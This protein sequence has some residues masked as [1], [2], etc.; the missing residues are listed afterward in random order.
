MGEAQKE[1]VG[2][3]WLMLWVIALLVLS[4]DFWFALRIGKHFEHFSLPLTVLMPYAA[5]AAA[6]ALGRRVLI[7]LII[8]F[9]LALISF[10]P[11]AEFPDSWPLRFIDT[12]FGDKFTAYV[13]S[14]AAVAVALAAAPRLH[15]TGFIAAVTACFAISAIW[16]AQFIQVPV[17][18]DEGIGAG[19][20]VTFAALPVAVSF[21]IAASRLLPLKGL[22]LFLSILLIGSLIAFDG[23][24]LRS[25]VAVFNFLGWPSYLNWDTS[26]YYAIAFL[27]IGAALAGT[28]F[29]T[30][31]ASSEDVYASRRTARYLIASLLLAGAGAMLLFLV[32]VFVIRAIPF[33]DLAAFVSGDPSFAWR[34]ALAAIPGETA[35][36]KSV[37]FI[38]STLLP[39]FFMLAAFS[40][41]YIADRSWRVTVFIVCLIAYA[42]GEILLMQSHEAVEGLKQGSL[43]WIQNG[44]EMYLEDWH[45]IYV[46]ASIVFIAGRTIARR[47]T[48][49]P[50]VPAAYR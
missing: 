49:Q 30:A 14:L 33:G 17:T 38:V 1:K 19:W 7:V 37:A 16:G 46:L 28:G 29:S 11:E 43:Y 35:D 24:E 26:Q 5:V 22:L 3:G 27:A 13:L 25:L 20:R 2:A 40:A 32:E 45:G 8:F 48:P 41:G 10:E 44:A 15:R 9:P 34:N 42:G 23:N 4:E 36:H 47:L 39:H 50:A 12:R 31:R 21:W 18:L 6:Q